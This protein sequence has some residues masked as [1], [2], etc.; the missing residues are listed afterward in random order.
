[1]LIWSLGWTGAEVLLEPV[2]ISFALVA[3]TS[4]AFMFVDVPEPV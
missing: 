2:R 1:M 3:S 4:L